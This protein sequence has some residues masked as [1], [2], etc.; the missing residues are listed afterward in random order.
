[1][2]PGYSISESLSEDHHWQLCRCVRIQDALSVLIRTTRGQSPDP[3]L[4]EQLQSEYGTLKNINI[5][6]VLKAHDLVVSSDNT[7]LI[8]EDP[9]GV[10][11]EKLLASH[12]FDIAEFLRISIQI[13][14][15]I[16]DLH[17]HK[18]VHTR[19]Q[20]DVVLLSKDGQKT[21]LSGFEYVI[22]LNPAMQTRTQ[23][24]TQVEGRLAYIAPEQT[25]RIEKN[26]DYRTDLYSLGIIFY[27]M[28]TGKLPFETEDPM[29]LVHCHLARIP[30][31]AFRCR[32][33]NPAAIVRYCHAFADEKSG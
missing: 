19:L 1:M 13:T 6:G 26:I 2:I 25:G 29:E 5:P 22:K 17:H 30:P 12:R 24:Q 31:G 9:G 32:S 15:I 21:W 14:A 7:A 11:L 27:E 16:A 20:P 10:L 8:L 33:K 23:V 4:T 28:L 18:I 3:L